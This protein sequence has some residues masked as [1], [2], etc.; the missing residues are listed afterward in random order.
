[1]TENKREKAIETA[2]KNVSMNKSI[3]VVFDTQTM[4]MLENID[5]NLESIADIL[6]SKDGRE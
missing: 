6:E 4:L 3:I 5:K 1:M 2:F